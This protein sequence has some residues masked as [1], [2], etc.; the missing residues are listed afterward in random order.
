MGL[1]Q[2]RCWPGSWPVVTTPAHQGIGTPGTIK[3]GLAEE[4]G[5]QFRVRVNSQQEHRVGRGTLRARE[6]HTAHPAGPAICGDLPNTVL[7]NTMAQR[8]SRGDS[9]HKTFRSGRMFSSRGSRAFRKTGSVP[10]LFQ[11]SQINK[12]LIPAPSAL[13][14]LYPHTRTLSLT[15]SGQG[16]H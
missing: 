15:L 6:S 12:L 4:H 1:R 16:G 2:G 7:S 14:R 8:R 5:L 9:T 10:V 13:Q 3:K 11:Q